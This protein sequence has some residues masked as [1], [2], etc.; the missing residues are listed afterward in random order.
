M[1]ITLSKPSHHYHL[2]ATKVAFLEPENQ[3]IGSLEINVLMRT[4]DRNFAS[5]E[6]AKAQQI[7]QMQFFEKMQNETLEVK[8]VFFSSISYLGHMTEDRFQERPKDVAGIRVREAP[9]EDPFKP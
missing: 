5:A 1:E 7:A 8:D 2:C 9:V 6:L 3:A 4:K